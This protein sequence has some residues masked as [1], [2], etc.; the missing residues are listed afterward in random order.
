LLRKAEP[1]NAMQKNIRQRKRTYE[2]TMNLKHFC[3]IVFA[4]LLGAL[5]APALVQGTRA[6][7]ESVN[8]QIW[9]SVE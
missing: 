2:K 6:N 5:A 8:V 9:R 1:I 7:G 3:S 4:T